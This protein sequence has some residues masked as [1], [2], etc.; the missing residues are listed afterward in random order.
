MTLSND[1]VGRVWEWM[2]ATFPDGL[3]CSACHSPKKGWG[4]NGLVHVPLATR[5]GNLINAPTPPV[6]LLSCERCGHLAFFD[7]RVIGLV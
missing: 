5:D 7:A 6:V 3:E 2:R 1:E 4:A